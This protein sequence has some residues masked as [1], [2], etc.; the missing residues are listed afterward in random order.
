MEH[1][2]R[3]EEMASSK[4]DTSFVY[5]I[6]S[7][8]H[9]QAKAHR[10][11]SYSMHVSR[12]LVH[13]NSAKNRK[14][15]PRRM[16]LPANVTRLH[17]ERRSKV[18]VESEHGQTKVHKKDEEEKAGSSGNRRAKSFKEHSEKDECHQKKVRSF[19]TTSKGLVNCGDSYEVK[20][21]EEYNITDTPTTSL[22]SSRH[23][24]AIRQHIT[25][26]YHLDKSYFRV[27]L[28]GARDV[29]KTS[30]IKQFTPPDFLAQS[31][32]DRIVTLQVDG[33]ESTLEFVQSEDFQ[34][35]DENLEIDA[36]VVVYCITDRATFDIAVD[37][38][39]HIRD[40][41]GSNKAII[42]V[43]NKSD[44]ERK[45][46]I[47]QEEGRSAADA[48]GCKYIELSAAFNHRVDE[49]L[50]G[51]HKQIKL[52]SETDNEE[53]ESRIPKAKER[54]SSFKRTKRF[55]E[56]VFHKHSS[57]DKTTENLYVE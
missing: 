44:L 20:P 16:S 31:E 1:F 8:G 12:P 45:R 4:D 22:D 25:S 28:T 51:I 29:G 50:V 13:D 14:V 19:K 41:V 3:G 36:F 54:R 34:E 43:G 38:L 57:K 18:A 39:T 9:L 49:L 23:T 15:R 17:K 21:E 37:L 46:T 53:T 55:L 2:R 11:R 52:K 7:E 42:L 6:L 35:E 30:L 27:L 26:K 5:D 48:C 56:K 32:G 47:S 24:N 40:E 10:S 33:E